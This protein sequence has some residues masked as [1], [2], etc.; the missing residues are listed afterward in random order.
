M[1]CL[2]NYHYLFDSKHLQTTVVEMGYQ[3]VCFGKMNQQLHLLIGRPIASCS[4]VFQTLVALNE[5]IIAPSFA[6]FNPVLIFRG[7]YSR[8]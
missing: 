7:T 1:K 4:F 2:L 8:Y 3:F 6:S 5:I